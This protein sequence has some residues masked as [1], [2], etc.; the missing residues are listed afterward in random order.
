LPYFFDDIF[1]FSSLNTAQK[2]KKENFSSAFSIAI[3]DTKVF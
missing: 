1:H 3:E 2:R